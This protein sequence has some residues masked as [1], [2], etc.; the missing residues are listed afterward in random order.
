MGLCAKWKCKVPFLKITKNSE[1]GSRALH[2]V[3]AFLAGALYDYAGHMPMKLY[4]DLPLEN[5]TET[6]EHELDK[7]RGI[8]CIHKREQ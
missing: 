1:R 3:W 4:L 2:K 8:Q 6:Q 7:R 5:G